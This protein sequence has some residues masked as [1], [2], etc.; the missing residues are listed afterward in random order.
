MTTALAA[1]DVGREW[2]K[3]E[4]VNGSRRRQQVVSRLLITRESVAHTRPGCREEEEE[5]G[6]AADSSGEGDRKEGMTIKTSKTTATMMMLEILTRL[7]RDSF[8]SSFSCGHLLHLQQLRVVFDDVHED[9][10]DVP[11]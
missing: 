2:T 1:R 5:E 10:I 6:P 8:P 3:E 9:S 11:A 4:E 7:P